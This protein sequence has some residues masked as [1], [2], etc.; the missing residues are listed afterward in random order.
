MKKYF[1]ELI[2]LIIQLF[3]FYIF[4]MFAGPTDVMGMVL[5]IIITTFILAILMGALSSEK[6]KYVYPIIIA[7]LFLPSVLIYYN[8]SAFIHGVW[9]LVDAYLGLGLGL[10][11]RK[12]LNIN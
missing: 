7:L 10:I 12:I 5:L 1:K 2:I 6:I 8:D 11:I 4:P 9:Y 3:M